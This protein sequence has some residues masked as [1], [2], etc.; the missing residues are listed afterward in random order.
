[1]ATPFEAHLQTDLEVAPMFTEPV[2]DLLETL[3]PRLQGLG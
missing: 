2:R 1:M 3:F